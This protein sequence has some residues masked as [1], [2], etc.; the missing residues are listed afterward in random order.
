MSTL[1][2][3]LVGFFFFFG[4]SCL[5]DL[6]VFQSLPFQVVSPQQCYPFTSQHSDFVALPIGR[7]SYHHCLNVPGFRFPARPCEG[8]C[9]WLTS[10]PMTLDL[11]PKPWDNLQ[12]IPSS[13]LLARGRFWTKTTCLRT[14]E[15][16]NAYSWAP[17]YPY[18]IRIAEWGPGI[19]VLDNCPR[20]FLC[21]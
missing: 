8:L 12:Q 5:E 21:T 1:F 13:W 6:I 7:W 19:C 11:E 20:W 2:V 14:W 16:E 4:P 10:H 3:I 18:W 9:V 15:H 17:A